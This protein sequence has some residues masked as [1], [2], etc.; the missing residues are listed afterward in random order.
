MLEKDIYLTNVPEDYMKYLKRIAKQMHI[1]LNIA[2]TTT[3]AD[4]FLGTFFLKNLSL[5]P[6]E[7]I[8]KTEEIIKDEND[9]EIYNEMVN[10]VNKYML[11]QNRKE[12]ISYELKNTKRKEKAYKL[13]FKLLI[14]KRILL[15]MR[16]IFSFYLLIQ[17]LFLNFTKMKI[18]LKI[19]L[20][21]KYILT[22]LLIK[23]LEKRNLLKT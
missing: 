17:I 6:L 7:A 10:I 18:I 1:P 13:V 19:V 8:K 15:K 22:Q 23:I 9:T 3:L 14:I 16:T 4:T 12:F 20:N 2:S 11:F 21:K 5:D